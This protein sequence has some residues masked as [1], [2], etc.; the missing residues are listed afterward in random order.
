MQ[1]GAKGMKAG[2]GGKGGSKGGQRGVKGRRGKRGQMVFVL[3]F[4]VPTTCGHKKFAS[5]KNCRG[6][7]TTST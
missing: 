7:P 4:S 5:D 6:V 2:E 3:N 1:R